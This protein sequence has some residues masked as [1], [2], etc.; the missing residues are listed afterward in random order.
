MD[1]EK[2]IRQEWIK[3]ERKERN[4]SRKREMKGMDKEI[5]K[6]EEWIKK[7]RKERNE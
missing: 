6:R 3:K 7:E 1:K 5:D 2:E 4:G